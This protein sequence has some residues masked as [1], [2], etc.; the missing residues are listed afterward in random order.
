MRKTHRIKLSEEV[1]QY[2]ALPHATTTSTTATKLSTWNTNEH[3][4]GPKPQTTATT[5]LVGTGPGVDRFR[6]ISKI[7]A[8]V[9][10]L[11]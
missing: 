7:V 11:F 6:L 8:S 3:G 5:M 10:K 2:S 1:V 4:L 9:Q